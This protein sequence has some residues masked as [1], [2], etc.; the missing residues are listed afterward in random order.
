MHQAVLTGEHFDEGA[1]FF[2]GHD[3]AL[4]D[5]ADFDLGAERFDFAAGDFHAF[6]GNGEHLHGS[7][8][9]DVD[10]ATG[11]FDQALDV[12]A[13]RSNQRADLLGVDLQGDDARGVLGNIRARSRQRGEHVGQD[14]ATGDTSLLDGLL[15]DRQRDALEL[16]IQL[17]AGDALLG[18]G[19]LAIHVAERVFPADDVGQ[20]LVA[21]DLVIG[22]V[23]GANTDGD[24]R[25]RAGD[26]HTGIHEGQRRAT[27]R[28]HRGGTIGF[29]DLGGDADGVGILGEG[30]HR[31][32]AALS[33]SAVANFAAAGAS[34]AAG[35]TDGVVREAVVQQELLLGCAT[36]VG[37][38]LLDVVA[39]AQGGQADG[40][41]LAAGE[42]SRTVGAGQEAH[43][44][45]QGAD[46][47][48][49]AA[50]QTLGVVEDEAADRF[51]LDVIL[52]IFDDEL[53]HL[54]GAEL[55]DELL[56]DFGEDRVDGGLAGQLLLGEEGRDDAITR[57]RLGGGENLF[58]NDGHRD[59][60]L[61]LAGLGSQFFLSGDQGL[62]GG[63]GEFQGGDEIGL[64]D[65]V[66][67]TFV[68]DHVGLVADIDE[69]EVGLGLLFVGGVH[70]E[71]TGD[72]GDADGAERAI[73]RDVG[74]GQCGR[75]SEDG[76]DV[77][78]VLAVGREQQRLD[79]NF[80]VPALGE[81]RA[82]GAIGEAAGE[83][84]LLG[85]PAFT[86][87]VS[88]GETA[89]GRC[90]LAV[91][92]GEGEEILTGLGLGGRNRCG[93]DDGFAELNGHGSVGLLCKAAG[94]DGDVL[95][96]DGDLNGMGH[97]SSC[98]TA[99]RNFTQPPPNTSLC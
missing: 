1:E 70:H 52:G 20:E 50:V 82:D 41:G 89:S 61:G 55:G 15:H 98:P 91:I 58:R 3:T 10:F 90:L 25:H 81:E 68:H 84:L 6:R 53:G 78:V 24:T 38:E 32:N 16:Q 76:E 77:G 42:H 93:E 80:I 49:V 27:D 47:V 88:A 96:T 19:D 9:L 39:G 13:A 40:L 56:T 66:G 44:A 34:D 92:H 60:A 97:T 26:G 46:C 79:L 86:L 37:V 23:L 7:V 5:L 43:F 22:A 31:A 51:L 21:G 28:S 85:G 2:D 83:D 99:L 63:L 71:L 14:L 87:E 72:A 73:P 4:V 11:L 36:G 17:E 48:E 8:V 57:Q 95:T 62:A 59:G 74:N 29:H 65:F 54:V 45:G 18:S 75:G 67:G 69:V 64:C 94:F 30:D 12:F 35:L 33:Q